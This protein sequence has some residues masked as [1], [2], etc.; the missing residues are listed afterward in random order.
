[1][2][3]LRVQ[4]GLRVGGGIIKSCSFRALPIHA[5]RHLIAV[6]LYRAPT[7]MAQFTASLTDR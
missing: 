3:S 6:G 7:I 2:E 5:V 1:M 4:W